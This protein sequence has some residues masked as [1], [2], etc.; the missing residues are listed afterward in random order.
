MEKLR[1]GIVGASGWMAGALA[2]G[3]EYEEGAGPTGENRKKCTTSVVTGLFDLDRAGAEQR[4]TELGLVDAEFF[5]SYEAMLAS[6]RVDAIVLVVPNHLHAGMAI[7]ALEAGKHLFLEKPFSTTLEDARRLAEAARRSSVTTKLD[8]I[9]LHYDEQENLRK[10]VEQGVFGEV[11]SVYFTYRHPIQI[12]A[13]EGQ[14]WKLSREKSGGALPMGV[15]HAVSMSV[16]QIG[17]VPETVICRMSPA[18]LRPFDYP[19]QIDLLIAFQNGVTA[20]IQ[21]NIDFAEKYDAR[22]TIVGTEGQFDYLPYLSLEQRVW[23]SSRPLGREYSADPT[24]AKHHL[25]SGDVWKHQCSRTVRDFVENARAGRKD[26]LLGLESELVLACE[27]IIWAC[28]E[29]AREGGRPVS[30]ASIAL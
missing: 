6:D 27:R 12:G 8:Y 18:K 2:V 26:S 17:A 22:H 19:T 21:G 20:V 7:Q 29:S 11:G 15:C 30:A 14:K 25:D 9:M 16:Y 10:L 4:R 24:F 5:D 3:V 28:E 13:S 1:V 23:W